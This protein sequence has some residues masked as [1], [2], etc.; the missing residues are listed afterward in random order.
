MPAYQMCNLF[1]YDE[2]NVMPAKQLLNLSRNIAKT[3]KLTDKT[4]M[5][6][7]LPQLKFNFI[8]SIKML[9]LLNNSKQCRIQHKISNYQLNCYASLTNVK[10]IFIR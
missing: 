5:L 3:F 10:F 4:V 8:K 7:Q 2:E 6:A 9:R 1:S